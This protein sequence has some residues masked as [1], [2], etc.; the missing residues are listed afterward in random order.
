[1]ITN[2]EEITRELTIEEKCLI[3]I[4]VKGFSTHK[5]D[6]PIK[7]PDIIEAINGK[8]ENYK[9]TNKLTQPRLRKMIN[10][11]RSK[12]ILPLIGTSQGYYVSYEPEEIE[13][14]IQSLRER[15]NA[16]NQAAEGLKKYS[17]KL[18]KDVN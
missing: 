16:I 13:K 8:K 10:L 12:G 18:K 14:Q 17:Q 7:A 4:L 5:K 2:F 1:M 11:I 15:A 6:N 9:L 3:Y